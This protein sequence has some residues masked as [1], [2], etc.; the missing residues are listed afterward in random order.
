MSEQTIDQRVRAVIAEQL[1]VE[2]SAVVDTASLMDDLGA[3]SLDC[4]EVLIAIEEE[5]DIEITEEDA[6]KWF[7]VDDI[8]EYVTEHA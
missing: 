8:I 5:F 7:T 3:D 4:V 1:G 6:E 2:E